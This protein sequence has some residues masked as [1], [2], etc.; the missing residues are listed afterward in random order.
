MGLKINKQ[1]ILRELQGD[2]RS[3]DSMQKAWKTK[4]EQYL[5]ETYA[6]PYGNEQDG[7]SKIVS[8]DILKQLNWM[9]PT[10]ADPFL[11]TSDIIKCN[12]VTFEDVKAARQS[13]L[14]LN[15]QF[16]RKFNRYNFINK[17][18]RVLAT[19]GT[20]SPIKRRRTSMR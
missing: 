19:E 11:S 18:L 17:A 14:L 13:E 9:I 5:S 8:K 20:A 15:T 3:A 6:N 16:V 2:L 4:R 1:K 12:P 7:K 10:I